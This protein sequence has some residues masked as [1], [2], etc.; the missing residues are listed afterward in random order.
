[1]CL[2]GFGLSVS[3]SVAIDLNL[4]LIASRHSYDARLAPPINNTSIQNSYEETDFQHPVPLLQHAVHPVTT[5]IHLRKETMAIIRNLDQSYIDNHLACPPGKQKDELV[6]PLR[7]GLYIEVR[8]SSPGQGTYY[9]RYKDATSKTCHQKLGRTSDFSLAEARRKAKLVKASITMGADPRGEEKAKKAVPTLTAFFDDSY[10]PHVTPRK[11]SWKKDDS[12]FK[13]YLKEK[14]GTRR[15]NEFRRQEVQE[16]HAGLLGRKL[17]PAS[18]D[19]VVKLLRQM[20][21][22]AVEW[23][24]IP[25]SPI[26][27]IKLFNA[28]NRLEHYMD[29][30]Q[31]QGL[32]NVLQVDDNRAVCNVAL[33]LLCTGARLNE[34]LDAT[35]DQVDMQSRV[36]RISAAT[37]KSKRVRSVP[38]NDSAIELLGILR[39]QDPDRDHPHLFISGRTGERLGHVHK[40]WDRIRIKAA[41]PKLR[42]HD[43]RHQF[44]SFLVNNGRS[45]YEVQK[46]LGHS[47]HS[48]TERYAH[49]SS[50]SLMDAANTASAMIKGAMPAAV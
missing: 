41:L 35:W 47:S 30:S 39:N 26:A 22:K 45:L 11:R 43:L 20:M 49:L 33:F 4:E 46:I 32:L 19:H 31:L 40:V 27:R 12:L 6:D 1:M 17:S 34:A 7:T 10:L 25:V 28:D 36:W 50:A 42:L 21:N 23:D 29:P 18:A 44:A 24:V 14:F 13:N 38:L 15:L 16:F 2:C 9:L 8:A 37:S 5:H 48:V 3:S